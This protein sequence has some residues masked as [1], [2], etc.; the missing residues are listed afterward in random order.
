MISF[1]GLKKPDDRFPL[2]P[3]AN[4]FIYSLKE[5]FKGD[6]MA[7]LNRKMLKESIEKVTAEHP[8]M[9]L[10]NWFENSPNVTA[11]IEKPQSTTPILLLLDLI[12]YYDKEV[13]H[14]T[15]V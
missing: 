14:F 4:V 10:L 7:S 2:S 12:A 5:L 11:I 1:P 13:N 3:I 6:Q 9:F 8:R 15:T